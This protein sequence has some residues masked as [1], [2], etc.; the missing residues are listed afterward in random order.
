MPRKKPCV[1]AVPFDTPHLLKVKRL[2]SEQK[3]L[4]IVILLLAFQSPVHGKLYIDK[5]LPINE[6]DLA[7]EASIFLESVRGHLKVIISLKMLTKEDGVFC[8]VNKS[9]SSTNIE[10]E[11]AQLALPKSEEDSHLN[12]NSHTEDISDDELAIAKG[13]GYSPEEWR[14]LKNSQNA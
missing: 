5:D 2:S 3:W 13:M 4:W 12:Q 7:Q 6:E 8:L 10:N 9:Q 11:E 14:E 1:Q